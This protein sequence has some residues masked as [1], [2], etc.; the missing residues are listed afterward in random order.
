MIYGTSN[1]YVIDDVEYNYP[2][3]NNKEWINLKSTFT[4]ENNNGEEIIY[5][6]LLFET[7]AGLIFVN[8]GKLYISD[9][10]IVGQDSINQDINKSNLTIEKYFDSSYVGDIQK[11]RVY[12]NVLLSN[13]ILHNAWIESINNPYL[14]MMVSKG[15]RII[16]TIQQ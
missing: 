14:E 8:D 2:T 16:N 12:D 6:G 10:N 13:E 11:L 5:V 15:G 1:I 9:Y 4:V 7:N 3:K